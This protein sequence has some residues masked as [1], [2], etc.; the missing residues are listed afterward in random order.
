MAVDGGLTRFRL[1]GT[2]EHRSGQQFV[3]GR[4]YAGDRYERVHRVEP[5]GF[6]SHPVA[7]GIG[8]FLAARGQRDS[9]YVFGG[10]NPSLRPAIPQGGSAQYDDKGN[11]ILLQGDAGAV[12]DFKNR[13]ATLSAGDW[14][15]N[16]PNGVTINGNVQVNGNIVATGTIVDGDGDG[17]A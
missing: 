5:H 2:V 17:G 7:G 11:L 9:G 15:I 4:G 10:E 12:F 3:D 1:D 8:T 16:A 13:T 6:A 14:T